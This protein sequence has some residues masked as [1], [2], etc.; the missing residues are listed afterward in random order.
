MAAEFEPGDKTKPPRERSR[1]EDRLKS[2][3][4]GDTLPPTP[5]RDL[6]TAGGANVFVLSVDRELVDTVQRAAGEHYPVFVVAQWSELDD[7]IRSGRCGIAL[8]DGDLL[9]A[10]LARRIGQLDAHSDRIVVLV[11]AQRPKAEG[12][13]G[14]LSER[15]IHRLLIKPS[16]PGIT[17]LLIESAVKRCLQLRELKEAGGELGE[18]RFPSPRATQRVPAWVFPSA[19]VALLVVVGLV[20]G[21]GSWS[22][23]S[24]TDAD[25]AGGRAAQGRVDPASDAGATQVAVG[26]TSTGPRL[27]EAAPEEA[28]EPRFAD[29]LSRA[30]QAFREGRLTAP[31]GDNALDYYLTVLAADPAEPT[32]R[33]E[34]AAVVDALFS[35]AETAL[36]ASRTDAAAAALANVRR[37]DPSSGRLQFLEAQLER[38]RNAEARSTATAEGEPAAGPSVAA[39]A[40]E[41]AAAVR[42]ELAANLIAAARRAIAA[43]DPD[44]AAP[45]AA[46]ARRIGADDDELARL[47][48]E[49]ARSRAARGALRHAEWLASAQQRLRDNALI[50]PEADSA[51]HYLA[52]LQAEAPSFPGLDAAWRE[53]RSA[54]SRAARADLAARRW[55]AAG[56]WLAALGQAP[57]GASA[58]ASLAEELEFGRRQER[59]LAAAAAAGEFTLLEQVAPVYPESAERRGQEGWVDLE[60]TIDAMGSVRDVTV[61]AADPPGRFDDAAVAAVS[62]YRFA[63]FEEE[64][65]R[66]ARRAR[67][68]VR[69]TLE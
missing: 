64:G 31:P 36:L 11:A 42:A 69:F 19:G 68:R 32:A 27:A 8:L 67:L 40:D 15:K 52:Q 47:D 35:Q 48:G 33:R 18:R 63:P 34:L 61:N 12:L 6:L 58:A 10:E 16:A 37:A 26:G 57:D 7:E 60:F 9:G 49:V 29:L 22:R 1:A 13:M 28:A 5:L 59:Y 43:G 25:E 50:T 41:A 55:D 3:S 54:V 39:A 21:L 14:F 66:Y 44:A 62:Q 4:S 17:R 46:E 38:A 53:W 23:G 65:R 51:N 20:I 56:V 2:A 45:L 24:L 30:E